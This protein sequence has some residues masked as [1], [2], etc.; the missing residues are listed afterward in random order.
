MREIKIYSIC[1]GSTVGCNYEIDN[2]RR[3]FRYEVVSFGVSD[4]GQNWIFRE[5]ASEGLEFSV[6]KEYSELLIKNGN[7]KN[8]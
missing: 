2:F 6:S 7:I 3:G 5:L 1:I 8:L 4:G